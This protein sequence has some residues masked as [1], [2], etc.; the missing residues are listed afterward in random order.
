MVPPYIRKSPRVLAALPWLYLKGIS[1]G[2]MSEALSV[3]LGEEAEGLL[4]NA[5]S[6]LKARWSDEWQQCDRRDVSAARYVYWW[7]DGIHTGVRSEGADGQC[8]LVIVGVTPDG[9]KECVAIADGF[10]ESTASWREVLL[11]L[12][13]R[14]LQCGPLL[15]VGAGA[16]GFWAAC[17]SRMVSRRGTIRRNNRNSPPDGS[18]LQTGRTR[19]LT[20][21]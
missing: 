14:G 17:R 7:A 3:L 20:L 4:A 6:R 21:A 9:N 11:D 1:T 5:V 16:M 18:T 10:R 2:D 8:L 13:A 19:H 12:N 15:P